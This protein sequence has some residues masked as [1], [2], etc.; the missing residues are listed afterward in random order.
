M[1]KE[2]SKSW[3]GSDM[4]IYTVYRLGYWNNSMEAIGKL[5][6]RRREERESNAADM[7]RL[8]KKVYAKSSTDSHIFIIAEGSSEILGLDVWPSTSASA[9]GR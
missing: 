4:E 9:G 1:E 7:L 5:V 3:A 2:I 8:A 6:E